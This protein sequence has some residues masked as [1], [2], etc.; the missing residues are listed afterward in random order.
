MSDSPPPPPPPPPAA[1][2]PP[3]PYGTP[4]A[5]PQ[6][7][8]PGRSKRTLWIVLGVVGVV[9]LLCLGGGVAG[10]VA[11]GR[12]A[13]RPADRPTIT[14]P[15]T[16]APSFG[17]R[18]SPSAS[19]VGFGETFSTP[20]GL[21]LSVGRPTT[22]ARTRRDFMVP[23]GSAILTFPVR[24]ENGTG[25]PFTLSTVFSEGAY[26]PQRTPVQPLLGGQT[27]TVQPG[28]TGSG[29][30]GFAVPSG[31]SGEFTVALHTGFSQPEA[32][33]TGQVG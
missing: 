15:S 26:G 5:V 7:P 12:A 2:P 20:D 25:T 11:L 3:P 27:L 14:L 22:R 17:A 16:V 4:Y 18:P 10:L 29:S 31:F 9:V 19:P 28:T 1:P 8:P 13:D 21:E 30:I 32:V 23:E 24:A 6:G 33:F